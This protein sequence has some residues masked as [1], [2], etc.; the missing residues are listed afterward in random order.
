M[1]EAIAGSPTNHERV[2]A[3][4]EL[5]NNRAHGERALITPEVGVN[6]N[7]ARPPSAAPLP[8]L[9]QLTRL[10]AARGDGYRP[11][12]P[13]ST[14]SATAKPELPA[15]PGSQEYPRSRHWTVSPVSPA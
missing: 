3:L 7:E 4:Y 1:G 14:V 13:G 11:G 2:E 12:F 15:W 10:N 8:S 6:E 5:W 9:Q